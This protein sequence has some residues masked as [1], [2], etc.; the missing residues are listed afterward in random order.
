V[1]RVSDSFTEIRTA[2]LCAAAWAFRFR[3]IDRAVTVP[4]IHS[5]DADRTS[6]I[7]APIAT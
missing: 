4:D 3:R 6:A 5:I 7:M 1:S 2:L